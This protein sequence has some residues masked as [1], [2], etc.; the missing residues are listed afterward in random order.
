LEKFNRSFSKNIK[1]KQLLIPYELIWMNEKYFSEDKKDN[2]IIRMKK[3]DQKEI[4]DKI[5]K[6]II[7]IIETNSRTSLIELSSK[8]KLTAQ[9]ISKR[10]KNLTRKKIISGFKL[11]TNHEKLEKGYHHIFI[12][13]KDFSKIDEIISYYEESK[14]CVFIMKYHGNYDFHMELISESQ[15][16][17]RETIKDFREKFGDIISD[18]QHLTI[19]EELKLTT[20]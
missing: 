18:Y 10:I 3:T 16:D 13:L 19:L 14:H 7:N 8:I 17:F 6:K 20:I 2:Y 12:S 11:R 1:E 9:A 5:D 15:N 4:I